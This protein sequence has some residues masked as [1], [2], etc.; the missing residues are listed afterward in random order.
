M[1][2]ELLKK[3]I[4]SKSK[5]KKP[6]GIKEKI[7]ITVMLIIITVGLILDVLQLSIIVG[8][9]IFIFGLLMLIGYCI[10]MNLLHSTEESVSNHHDKIVFLHNE[11]RKVLSDYGIDYTKDDEI[12]PLIELLKQRSS[13]YD[14]W[15]IMS[16]PY[17]KIISVAILPIITYLLTKV[18]ENS[19]I[20]E[21]ISGAVLLI[22]LIIMSTL[23]L[24]ASKS[25]LDDTLNRKK[26]QFEQLINELERIKVFENCSFD[27]PQK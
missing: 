21:I 8:T 27:A 4:S 24:W 17:G 23:S 3:Y 10:R 6:Y 13:Q 25:L 18:A 9:I 12:D 15:G 26:R 7:Y 11:L 14:F 20:N 5:I 1:E 22:T 19:T 16:F 2:E